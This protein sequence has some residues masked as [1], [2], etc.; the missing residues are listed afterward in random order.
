[1]YCVNGEIS[2]A[3]FPTGSVGAVADVTGAGWDGVA[4]TGVGSLFGKGCFAELTG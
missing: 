2:R 4:G 3:G 1:M